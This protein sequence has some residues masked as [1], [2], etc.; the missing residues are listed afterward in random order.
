MTNAIQM[1]ASMGANASAAR[2]SADQYAAAIAALDADDVLAS[3]LLDRDAVA[4]SQALGGRARMVCMVAPAE[5]E[6]PAQ[7]DQPSQDDTPSKDE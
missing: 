7:Q 3:A 2:M 4:I 6:Q 5:E 1:L